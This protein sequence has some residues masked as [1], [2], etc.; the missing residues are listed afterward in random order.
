MRKCQ[1]VHGGK[2]TSIATG[3]PSVYLMAA[4]ISAEP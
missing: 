1:E 3:T 4:D 2:E